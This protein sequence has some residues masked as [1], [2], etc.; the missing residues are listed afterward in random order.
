LLLRI[1]RLVWWSLGML[2]ACATIA[3]ADAPDATVMPGEERF[4]FHGQ[5][6][7]IEQE[8]DS[9]K[10]PYAGPNSLSPDQGRETTDLTLFAGARLWRGA[11]I[12]I[13]PEIDEGFG[14]NDTLGVAGFPSGEAYKV[15]KNQ[16]YLRWQ[17]F[18]V[19]QTL[20][21]EGDPEPVAADINQLGGHH[22][23]K[24]G[25]HARQVQRRGCLRQQ[26]ICP[27]SAQ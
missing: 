6:T 27:R 24:L 20:D 10:A 26:S 9:F 16:P 21:L 11:E 8:T 15:G 22:S 13:N 4:A 7:Y 2:A 18:F 19:R 1:I 14:L 17:R 23:A 5:F 12:W 3:S 25:V